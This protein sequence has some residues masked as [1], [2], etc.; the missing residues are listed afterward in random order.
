MHLQQYGSISQV[1]AMAVYKIP[2][3]AARIEEIRT[4]WRERGYHASKIIS[5]R[6]ID[7]EGSRYVKYRY[8]RN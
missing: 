3:L 1:E 6:K 2:R 7:A 8:E 4:M 5:E